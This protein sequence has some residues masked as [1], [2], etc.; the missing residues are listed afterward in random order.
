MLADASVDQQR[1]AAGS[2]HKTLDRVFRDAPGEVDEHRLQR[3]TMR[4]DQPPIVSGQEFGERKAEIVVVDDDVDGRVADRK[5]HDRSF[6]ENRAS[7]RA[8]TMQ[9]GAVDRK[10]RRL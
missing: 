7:Q 8:V 3:G 5:L 4:F 9:V 1:S 6:P 2:H 10:L